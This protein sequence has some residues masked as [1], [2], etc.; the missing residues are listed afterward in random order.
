MVE[1][2]RFNVCWYR[3][4]HPARHCREMN[5]GHASPIFF[6][7]FHRTILA[8]FPHY[9]GYLFLTVIVRAPQILHG[10]SGWIGKSQVGLKGKKNRRWQGFVYSACGLCHCRIFAGIISILRSSAWFIAGEQG[11]ATCAFLQDE[12]YCSF[13][14][15]ELFIG[16]RRI[17]SIRPWPKDLLAEISPLSGGG[18]GDEQGQKAHPDSTLVIH[19]GLNRSRVSH[20]LERTVVAGRV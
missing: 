18:S 9:L 5:L 4:P 11:W 20:A 16:H 12:Y 8:H 13:V 3:P 15:L 17:L 10:K 1:M 7:I 2:S 14:A 6:P 19:P